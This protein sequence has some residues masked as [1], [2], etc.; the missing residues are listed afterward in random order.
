MP[1]T[2]KKNIT[3]PLKK[4]IIPLVNDGNNNFRQ[5]ISKYDLLIEAGF[6]ELA[7]PKTLPKF[8]TNEFGIIQTFEMNDFEVSIEFYG[9]HYRGRIGNY[10]RRKTAWIDKDKFNKIYTKNNQSENGGWFE[11][12]K[13]NEHGIYIPNQE[14][15]YGEFMCDLL[16]YYGNL[17][18]TTSEKH[19]AKNNKELSFKS[20]KYV[21]IELDKITKS[22][23]NYLKK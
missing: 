2:T 5:N 14:L 17:T 15:Y 16:P 8:P 7:I 3:H 21:I 23:L 6:D 13:F 12:E 22:L 18:L 10:K 20:K 1:K 9:N 11:L 19:M 4:Q